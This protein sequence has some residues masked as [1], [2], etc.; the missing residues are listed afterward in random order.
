MRICAPTRYQFSAQNAMARLWYHI[1]QE[2]AGR[3]RTLATGMELPFFRIADRYY[4]GHQEWASQY[5][6]RLGGCS[7]VTACE[8]SICMARDT[9]AR[10]MYPGDPA[11]VGMSD[12]LSFFELMFQ[13]VKPGFMGL[14]DIRKYADEFQEYASTR[15][16]RL[17]AEFLDGTATVQEAA[18][19]VERGIGAGL[20]LACLILQHKDRALDDFEW[21]WFTLTGYERSEGGF[22]VIAATY[23]MRHVL[24][25]GRLWNTGHARKGGIVRMY[26]AGH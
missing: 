1:A 21:H 26:P 9:A 10:A 2:I 6:M 8:I 20:P 16:V 3:R 14:T 22:R 25:L 17:G 23:A 11:H 24:D 15:G 7:T 12:F 19:F 5:M 18:R 4:G 13:Y